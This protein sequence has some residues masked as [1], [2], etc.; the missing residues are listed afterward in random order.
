MTCADLEFTNREDFVRAVEKGTREINGKNFYMRPPYQNPTAQTPDPVPAKPSENVRGRRT[1]PGSSGY[2][3]RPAP[4]TQPSQ[5]LGL[6]KP[7]ITSFRKDS[8]GQNDQ[9]DRLHDMRGQKPTGGSLKDA[10]WSRG[11]KPMEI[12][13]SRPIEAGP[14][15]LRPAGPPAAPIQPQKQPEDLKPTA[16]TLGSSLQADDGWGAKRIINS[17]K[18]GRDRYFKR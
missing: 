2:Q 13:N 1:Q 8:S 10:D 6:N 16:K 5:H 9:P 12:S 15:L 18:P 17:K 7:P 4:E 14:T 11:T 3:S